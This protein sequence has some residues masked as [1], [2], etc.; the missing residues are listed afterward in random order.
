[1]VK[2]D[3]TMADLQATRL[4]YEEGQ[5]VTP[6]VLKRAGK[7]YHFFHEKFLEIKAQYSAVSVDVWE[8]FLAH[9]ISLEFFAM[10]ARAMVRDGRTDDFDI[11]GHYL[12][13]IDSYR[14]LYDLIKQD[15]KLSDDK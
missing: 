6:E 10:Q 14:D 3:F 15:F 13:Y 1:M 12:E 9:D 7:A 4:G 5:D 2:I 8:A 11:F